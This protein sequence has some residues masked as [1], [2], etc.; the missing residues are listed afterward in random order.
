MEALEARSVDGQMMGVGE[1]SLIIA[2]GEPVSVSET[3]VTTEHNT[4]VAW[5]LHQ[6]AQPA[7]PSPARAQG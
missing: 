7:Q 2:A 1:S 4:T 5:D 6:H 3:F